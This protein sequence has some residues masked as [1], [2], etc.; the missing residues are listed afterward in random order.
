MPV[1]KR[2]VF[3]LLMAGSAMTLAVPTG[4]I[5]RPAG[6]MTQL[7]AY[8]QWAVHQ[9]A[10]K[11][12][13]PLKALAR[14]QMTADQ[15]ARLD[16]ENKGL[17]N[18]NVVLR[19]QLESLRQ[20]LAEL[21]IL[22]QNGLGGHGAI[23]PAE[24]IAGD[25]AP[26]QDSFLVS[27]GQA[28]GVKYKDWVASRLFIQAGQ[29]DGVR[30]DA[31]VLS[32][33][34]LIGWVE[35]TATFTSRVVLLSDP[36]ANRGMRVHIAHYDPRTRQPR[37]V[38]LDGRLAEFVLRGAGGGSMIIRDIKSDFVDAG[39]V[40]VGDMVLS[41]AHD[42]RLGQSLVIGEIEEVRHNKNQPLLYDAVVRHRFDPT[43]LNQVLIVDQSRD[44]TP[45]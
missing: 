10:I 22:R 24:V 29:R 12:T 28:R 44:G 34:C 27:Q 42:A 1:S 9:A 19:Q 20:T 43:A 41:D 14:Q 39:V 18:E 8:P 37:Q 35:Q 15:Q 13:E 36:V 21:T 38:L 26:R 11:A 32:R 25:A 5:G 17:E 45:R 6:E 33:Q 2:T 31:A 7:I 40:A 30:N 16:E 23:I 3:F 4:F